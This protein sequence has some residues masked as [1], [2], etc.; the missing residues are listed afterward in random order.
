MIY[1]NRTT[2]GAVFAGIE[3]L[4]ANELFTWTDVTS[5][6]MFEAVSTNTCDN[7]DNCAGMDGMLALVAF[8]PEYTANQTLWV[9]PAG[10]LTA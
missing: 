4:V 10:R 8:A 1:G 2:F 3:Q 5:T 9:G 6:S 7:L